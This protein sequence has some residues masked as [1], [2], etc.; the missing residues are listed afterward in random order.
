MLDPEVAIA[1]FEV[2]ESLK[3]DDLMMC[4]TDQGEL[5]EIYDTSLGFLEWIRRNGTW[6]DEKD[7][8]VF[9]R[10]KTTS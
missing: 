6:L 1:V 8:P 5:Y 7:M 10:K 9:C 3:E 2:F 4:L